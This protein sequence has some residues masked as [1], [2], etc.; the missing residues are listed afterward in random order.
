M[1]DGFEIVRCPSCGLVFRAHMPAKRSS[2]PSTATS[3]SPHPTDDAE[4]G[5]TGYLD[6]VAD[7]DFTEST[8]GSGL[9]KLRQ[10]AAPGRAAGRRLCRRL[11]PRRGATRRLGAARDRAL[12]KHGR[13]GTR[14]SRACRSSACRSQRRSSSRTRYDA[15]TMWDYIEHSIDPAADLRRS[16]QFLKPGGPGALH[17]R[18][19]LARGPPV[20]LPLAPAHPAP[21]Q[22]LLPAT[23]PR[24]DARQRRLRASS[25]SRHPAGWYSVRYLAHKLRTMVDR[26]AGDARL[27]MAAGARVIGRVQV[28]VNLWDIMVVVARAR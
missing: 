14:T 5:A 13:V 4:I 21:P 3:T 6:Y 23:H 2:T 15:I 22:L 9:T 16:H 25:R 1:K 24:P 27:R 26:P 17:R 12:G 8:R 10:H 7:E 20:R 19:R 28:P 18:R 11:L